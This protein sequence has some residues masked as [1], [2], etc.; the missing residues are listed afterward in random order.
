M[1]HVFDCIRVERIDMGVFGKGQDP[2]WGQCCGKFPFLDLGSRVVIL[3]IATITLLTML[4]INALASVSLGRSVDDTTCFNGKLRYVFMR[5]FRVH[6]GAR[7][8]AMSSNPVFP[9][10][11]V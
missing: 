5:F 6:L 1:K 8:S 2:I 4:R 3:S 7:A 9:S 10:Y 11:C